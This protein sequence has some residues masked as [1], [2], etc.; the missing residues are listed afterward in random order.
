M[1]LTQKDKEALTQLN[2]DWFV[3]KGKLPIGSL[4]EVTVQV[5]SRPALIIKLND[6]PHP[7]AH[8]ID[9][10]A[11]DSLFAQPVGSLEFKDQIGR[12]RNFIFNND[13][14]TVGELA[15][16]TD[17]QLL[18]YRHLGKKGLQSIKEALAKK[19]ITN[20][21]SVKVGPLEQAVLMT[22][23]VSKLSLFY[24][25]QVLFRDRGFETVADVLNQDKRESLLRLLVDVPNVKGISLNNGLQDWLRHNPS[26]QTRLDCVLAAVEKVLQG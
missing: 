26:A 24:E 2:L 22:A 13:F 20:G 9:S 15:R 3:K 5:I 10:E 23:P 12:I 17:S 19:E 6:A 8:Q 21:V 16:K 1:I 25:I 18:Y 14:V 4:I 7:Q 11:L